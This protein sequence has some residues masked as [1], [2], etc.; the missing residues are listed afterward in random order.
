MV[1][2]IEVAVSVPVYRDLTNADGSRCVAMLWWY[3]GGDGGVVVVCMW[4][5]GWCVDGCGYVGL[6][7]LWEKGGTGGMG[8][9][10]RVDEVSSGRVYSF[11]CLR[12]VC[13]GV[14]IEAVCMHY[15]YPCLNVLVVVLT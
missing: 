8:S 4:E 14:C 3:D 12:C 13:F 9:G 5:K 7:G 6:C 15:L 10:A 11:I 2:Q 1:D